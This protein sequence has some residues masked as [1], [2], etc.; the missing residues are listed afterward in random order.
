MSS[1]K[2]EFKFSILD[3]VYHNRKC[4][5]NFWKM[6]SKLQSKSNDDTFKRSIP[7]HK[8]TNHF[9]SLFQNKNTT[10]LPNSLIETGDLDYGI[11]SKELEKASYILKTFKSLGIDGISNEMIL[12]LLKTNKVVFKIF[13]TVPSAESSIT[14]WNTS[15]VSPI[16]K[17]GSKAEPD[18][19]RAISLTS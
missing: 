2:K 16:H 9:K 8:W 14:A 17:K 11:M 18:N 7:G 3:Q 15:I 5:H 1:S 19:Y 10:Y 6:L 12:S 13:N 4:S